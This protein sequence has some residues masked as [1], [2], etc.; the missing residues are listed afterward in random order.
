M[1]AS[2]F[3]QPV[4]QIGHE[5]RLEFDRLVAESRLHRFW[6]QSKRKAPP[7]LPELRI[8]DAGTLN[9][10]KAH[11]LLFAVRHGAIRR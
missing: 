7:A 10:R 6:T 3:L 1:T 2:T 4:F 8:E 9:Q 11:A 5:L